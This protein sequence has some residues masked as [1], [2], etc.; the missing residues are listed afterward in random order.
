MRALLGV[1]NILDPLTLDLRAFQHRRDQLLLV[2]QNLGLLH[3]HLLLLL[4]LLH[5]HL[6]G[7]DL[8]LHHVRLQFIRLVGLR[9]LPTSRLGKLRLLDVEVALRLSLLREREPSRRSRAPDR[10]RPSRQQPRAAQ[11]HD[12]SPYRALPRRQQSRHRA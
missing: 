3:L 5:L 9:L 2:T 7:N 10:Q 11:P 1:R 4:D 8:L 6:F 12:E